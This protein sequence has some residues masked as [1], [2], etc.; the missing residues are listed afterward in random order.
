MRSSH[1]AN[2]MRDAFLERLGLE[3]AKT[4]RSKVRIR[5]LSRKN[6]RSIQNAED[7][8]K[9]LEKTFLGT[10]SRHEV[11][12]ISVATFEA[13]SF[14]DQLEFLSQ[15]DILISVHGAAL[16]GIPFQPKCAA[17]LELFPAGYV[18]PLFFG[19]LAAVS[20]V[21]HSFMYLGH[22]D[23]ERETRVGMK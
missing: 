6:N 22:Q 4:C 7:L 12:S 16:T 8:V 15:A 3:E 14:R 13:A 21:S 2:V 5:I 17:V 23:M 9:A 19:S 11:E 18:V 10:I 1:D 20:G